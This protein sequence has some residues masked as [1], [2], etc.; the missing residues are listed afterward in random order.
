MASFPDLSVKMPG[1]LLEHDL[2]P[3]AVIP[4]IMPEEE[5]API[6]AANANFPLMFTTLRMTGVII[7]TYTIF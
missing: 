1:V 5:C 2:L 6:A 7:F 3:F 4:D